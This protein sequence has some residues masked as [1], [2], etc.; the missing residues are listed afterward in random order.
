MLVKSRPKYIT[1]GILGAMMALLIVGL[2]YSQKPVQAGH[3]GNHNV[4]TGAEVVPTGA[5][6][7][8]ECKWELPDG[9][10]GFTNSATPPT[11]VPDPS[12]Q[13]GTAGNAHRHDDSSVRPDVSPACDGPPATLPTQPDGV[14]HMIQVLPLPHVSPNAPILERDIQLW[15]AVDHPNGI[16]NIDDVYWKIF[17]PDG[18]FKVQVH[19]TK[20]G[21]SDAAKPSN[22]VMDG[23]ASHPAM[24]TTTTWPSARLVSTPPRAES[25][26]AAS[27]ETPA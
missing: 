24:T 2:M 11:D 5:A 26:N 13:Y 6:P 23:G 8:I 7:F 22:L 25:L 20:I 17:H 21:D 4:Q 14:H 9:R 12:I 1:L 10:P 18:S 3:G 15:A 16:G 19:G 27:S